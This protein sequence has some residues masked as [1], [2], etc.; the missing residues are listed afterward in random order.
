MSKKNVIIN[1]QFLI[2]HLTF[3]CAKKQKIIYFT[4]DQLLSL[5]MYNKYKQVKFKT[6]CEIQPNGDMKLIFPAQK[7]KTPEVK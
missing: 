3:F 1:A 7:E 5:N 6:L 4:H 2:K